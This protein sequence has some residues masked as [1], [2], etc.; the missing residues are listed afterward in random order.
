M[1]GFMNDDRLTRNKLFV[2]FELVQTK[3]FK[4]I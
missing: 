3:G 4:Y 2:D 1:D